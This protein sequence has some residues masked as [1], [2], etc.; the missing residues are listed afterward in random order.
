M[1]YNYI[2]LMPLSEHPCDNSWG[3][4]I[5]EFYSPT[6]RYGTG[7]QLKKLID[8]C[9]NNGIGV[10]L[11]FIPVH[12][13][14]DD[15][16]LKNFDG[17]A[18]YEY[19]H[20]DVGYSEWDS[21]NF[22]HSRGEV[23]SFLQS[24]ACYWLKEFHFDG[25]RMDAVSRIIYWQGDERRGE[26]GLGIKF[27]KVINKELKRL[28]PSCMLI[29]EDSSGY[30]GVT[31][32]VDDNGLGFDYKWDM[33]FM[34]D[35]LSFLKTDPLHRVEN[36]HKLTFS[37]MYYYNENYMLTFSHDENVHGKATILQKMNGQ[38]E[39][40]FSQARTLYLYM[41]T[42]PGKKLNFMGGELGQLREWDESRE[43]DWCILKYP[44]HDSFHN[45]IRKLNRIYAKHSALY[46]YDYDRNGFKWLDCNNESN[47]IYAME[48]KSK[49][50]TIIGIFNFCKKSK[51]YSISGYEQY[52]PK[53][54]INTDWKEFGGT[55]GHNI[56][57]D[58]Q[59]IILPPFSGILIHISKYTA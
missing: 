50:E 5:T 15:Y 56:E 33:G 23:R 44:I 55:T 38:Y 30:S 46:E 24:C 37:M 27:L 17:S 10:I 6:S 2:E 8:K 19:P 9:H 14:V 47:C 51:N 41:Y 13:A 36:Y 48:R 52:I 40:K 57:I 49:N 32:K 26:N 25:L 31:K 3:Y 53:V 21:C 43:Q 58:L 16:G 42:H 39:D 54:L 35:T 45:F 7:I 20:R 12:F 29:A 59:N 11:D 22:M 28:F 18:L 4:Q 1:G 34:N